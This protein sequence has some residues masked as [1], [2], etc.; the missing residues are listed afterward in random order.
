VLAWRGDYPILFSRVVAA[1]KEEKISYFPLSDHD[2]LAFQP[3]SPRPGYGI[4]VRSEDAQR[5]E[6]IVREALDSD[7]PEPERRG[8]G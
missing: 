3:T 5:V 7:A 8:S 4:F 6:K 1:L 2:Q